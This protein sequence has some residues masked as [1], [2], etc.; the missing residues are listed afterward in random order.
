MTRHSSIRNTGFTPLDCEPVLVDIKICIPGK[1]GGTARQN[2]ERERE[3]PSTE[4]GR[5]EG[6][7]RREKPPRDV[8]SPSVDWEVLTSSLPDVDP[9][10]L[11]YL[12]PRNGLG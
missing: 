11:R 1:R 9:Q 8:K 7:R 3:R 5:G 10:D 6:E 4:R 2:P 12:R